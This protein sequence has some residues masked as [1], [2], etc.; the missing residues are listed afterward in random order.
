M[1]RKKILF[2]LIT[3]FRNRSFFFKNLKLFICLNPFKNPSLWLWVIN[4]KIYV[5]F[6]GFEG[7]FYYIFSDTNPVWYAI[8]PIKYLF[9]YGFSV[10]MIYY[11]WTLLKLETLR[12]KELFSYSYKWHKNQSPFFPFLPL[13]YRTAFITINKHN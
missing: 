7:I 5:D 10:Q 1:I 13:L 6:Y 4:T 9:D 12:I 11:P 3:A 2:R 8:K